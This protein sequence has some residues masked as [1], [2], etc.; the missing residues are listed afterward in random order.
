MPNTRLVPRA[1]RRPPQAG[2]D[3]DGTG[4][5]GAPDV[6]EPRRADAAEPAAPGPDPAEPDS[7]ASDAAAA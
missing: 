5:A 2:P 3:A 6:P 1:W 7:A 4:P